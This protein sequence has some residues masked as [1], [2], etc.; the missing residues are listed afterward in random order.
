MCESTQE[1]FSAK[2]GGTGHR[3]QHGIVNKCEILSQKGEL[4]Q[5]FPFSG[6]HTDAPPTHTHTFIHNPNS[7]HCR[8][9]KISWIGIQLSSTLMWKQR[10]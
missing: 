8:A 9:H 10:Y 7:V 2:L 6:Q 1:Y 5:H 3:R 4:F